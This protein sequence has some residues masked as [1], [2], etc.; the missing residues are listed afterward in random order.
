MSI[1]SEITRI[2]G[3]VSDSLDAVAA[4]GVTV[5][6]GSN[7]DDLPTLISQIPTG[8]FDFSKAIIH[9]IAPTGST[10]YFTLG[11]IVRGTIPPTD[12]ILNG[13]DS[14]FSDYFYEVNATDYGEWA[15]ETATDLR[16]VTVDAVGMYDVFFAS[17]FYLYNTGTY[18]PYYSKST[19]T[20]NATITDEAADIKISCNRN[21]VQSGYVYWDNVNLTSY[22][23]IVLGR[24]TPD[25]IARMIGIFITQDPS[26]K[27]A[28]DASIRY[29]ESYTGKTTTPVY[30]TLDISNYSGYWR[31]GVGCDSGGSSWSNARNEYIAS[32]MMF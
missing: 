23:M 12:S 24:Y 2:S 25:T 30:H 14:R 31:V 19:F 16:Y 6:T 13:T 15:I 9:V 8:G 29:Y 3:N 17:E 27:N 21:S 5:P 32:V 22:D 4:K 18:T 7:S 10:L 28:L 26:V 20:Q 1:S 11:G